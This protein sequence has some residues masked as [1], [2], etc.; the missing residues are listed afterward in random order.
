[1]F[2]VKSE[3]PQYSWSLL[4]VWDVGCWMMQRRVTKQERPKTFSIS[5][6]SYPVLV[7]IKPSV[8]IRG[9]IFKWASHTAQMAS[10]TTRTSTQSGTWISNEAWLTARVC[11]SNSLFILVP[12]SS[13][14]TCPPAGKRNCVSASKITCNDKRNSQLQTV[15]LQYDV[16]FRVVILV[17]LGLSWSYMSTDFEILWNFTS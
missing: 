6:P 13:R 10:N 8:S 4:E 1:M 15:K 17:C 3:L 12:L 16:P 5:I 11:C 2:T 7:S 9:N 14:I